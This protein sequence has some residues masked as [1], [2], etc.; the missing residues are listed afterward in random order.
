MPLYQED[1]TDSSFNHIQSSK[2][3]MQIFSCF[4]I[5][6]THGHC[7]VVTLCCYSNSIMSDYIKRSQ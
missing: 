1:S 4:A 5:F 6:H 3:K 7:N 2:P